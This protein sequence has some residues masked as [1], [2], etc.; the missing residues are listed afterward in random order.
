MYTRGI[1]SGPDSISQTK[2]HDEGMMTMHSKLFVG[3]CAAALAMTTACQ[4]PD[5]RAA[6]EQTIRNLDAQW[7]KTAGTHDVD[8]TVA[9]YSDD[10]V[11]LPP[12]A[13]IVVGKKAIRESWVAL[14][15]PNIALSWQ[16]KKIEVSKSG[17]LAY[18]VGTYSLTATD[19]HGN[20]N[21][22]RG[23]TVEVFKK[24][25]DGTWKVVADMYNSDLP[26]PPPV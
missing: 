23:K 5:T 7:S 6:D 22:D 19:A 15:S 24:E 2:L 21:T 1:L 18:V 9:Y 4:Q 8:G 16:S 11:L 25:A 26:A 12:N 17:D 3:I 10:A 13:P 20:P 14:L